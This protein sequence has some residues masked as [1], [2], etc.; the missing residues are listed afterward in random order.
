MYA[1]YT[2]VAYMY[3]RWLLDGFRLGGTLIDVFDCYVENSVKTAERERRAAHSDHAS[4]RYEVAADI[5][6]PVW[7]YFMSSTENEKDLI[8]IIRQYPGDDTQ[9][10]I[11]AESSPVCLHS[12]L[13]VRP[14]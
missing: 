13:P 9:Q 14:S 8:K 1:S 3:M 7:K 11:D 6:L 4:Q 10:H 5:S 12:W 2:H